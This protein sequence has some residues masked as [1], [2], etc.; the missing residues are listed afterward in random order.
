MGHLRL[1]HALYLI[2]L[3]LLVCVSVFLCVLCKCVCVCVCTHTHTHTYTEHL[4]EVRGQP[5]SLHLSPCL[6]QPL[7]AA[8]WARLTGPFSRASPIS[9]SCLF[10]G[11][12]RNYRCLYCCNQPVYMGS[13]DPNSSHQ[14]CEESFLHTDPSPQPI[15]TL[16]FE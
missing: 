12:H 13:R 15:F 11:T 14:G 5:S 10:V 4:Y 3:L 6:T 1:L 8:V 7:F 16:F 2:F 9:T